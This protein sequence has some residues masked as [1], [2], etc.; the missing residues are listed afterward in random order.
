MSS[1]VEL[2]RYPFKSMRGEQLTTSYFTATGV[3]GDRALALM[4]VQTGH[5]VSAKNPKKWPG[6]LDIAA[7]FVEAP[8]VGA[9]LPSV[10]LTF[11]DGR[12]MSSDDPDFDRLMSE[13]LGR[14]VTL[15]KVAPPRPTLEEY[16]P[17]IAELDH[18]ETVTDEQMPAGTF[19]DLDYVHILTTSTLEQLRRLYP[20]GAIDVRRFRPN[21]VVQLE[22]EEGFVESGWVGRELR[23]GDEVTLEITDHCPRCVMTTL[24]Q[25]GLPKDNGILRTVA[26][27]NDVHVGVYAKVLRGGAVREGDHVGLG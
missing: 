15:A 20:D 12:S 27:E 4:D 16:W 11:S 23:L 13:A 2:W 19:F 7:D 5:V 21:V 1:V 18:Q 6:M 25:A 14:T 10:R 24:A 8:R 22:G 3:F 9:P 17:D 26:R